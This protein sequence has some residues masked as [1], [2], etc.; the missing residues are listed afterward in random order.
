MSQVPI[1]AMAEV[2]RVG[3]LVNN[4]RL[5]ESLREA[6]SSGTHAFQ[7]VPRLIER[8]IDQ[9]AWRDRMT[10]GGERYRYADEGDFR[11]FITD[12]QPQGLGVSVEDVR[13]YLGDSSNPIRN[14]FDELLKKGQG[15][16]NN[17]EGVNQYPRKNADQEVNDNTIIVDLM[18]GD[19]PPIIRLRDE[20]DGPPES[21]A[22]KPRATIQGDSIGYAVRR[23]GRAAEDDPGTF[24]E[25]LKKGP[26]NPTGANQYS[27]K[28]R[29]NDNTDIISSFPSESPPVI[30]LNGEPVGEPAPV[31][32]KP[33][34]E[35][36]LGEL[37]QTWAWLQRNCQVK[38]A[39]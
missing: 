21:I 33:R 13:K 12:P 10:R 29:G 35:M 5:S 24:E 8:V 17:P 34:G 28:E 25:L 19:P 39:Q 20:P 16:N 32:K 14:K 36:T 27:P 26:G 1:A 23:L 4:Y 38:E 7:M 11:S 30:R 22:K 9:E 6:F 2:E 15:G 37:R 3:Q 31:A 18:P